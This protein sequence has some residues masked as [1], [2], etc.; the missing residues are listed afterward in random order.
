[1]KTKMLSLGGALALCLLAL[2]PAEAARID[3]AQEERD[4]K[5]G[6]SCA[7]FECY[8]EKGYAICSCPIFCPD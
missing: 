8:P 7:I 3:C 5:A 6:C 2:T 1:M 4:C